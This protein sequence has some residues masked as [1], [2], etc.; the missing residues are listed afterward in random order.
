MEFPRS[1][2][3]CRCGCSRKPNRRIPC[4]ICHHW[5]GPGCCATNHETG[6]P[7]AI[8][9]LCSGANPQEVHGATEATTGLADEECT[10]CWEEYLVDEERMFRQTQCRRI[11]L[12]IICRW[13]TVTACT[14]SIIR[15]RHKWTRILAERQAAK[16]SQAAEW[17][18][19]CQGGGSS[20]IAHLFQPRIESQER[21]HVAGIAGEGLK[22]ERAIA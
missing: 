3:Q 13:E 1:L 18:E 12:G 21:R 5:I 4:M 20:V 9:H 7:T 15:R 22:M 11:T 17:S 10:G 8:C 2:C 19:A 6:V 14:A 16:C